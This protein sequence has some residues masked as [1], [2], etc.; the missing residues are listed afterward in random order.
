M[1]TLKMAACVH[2]SMY[3]H[4]CAV[5]GVITKANHSAWKCVVTLSGYHTRPIYD[6]RWLVFSR[7]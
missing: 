1:F 6:V 5:S 7:I 4:V 2:V 3:V